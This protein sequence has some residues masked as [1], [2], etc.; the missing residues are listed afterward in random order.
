[1]CVPVR[2]GATCEPTSELVACSSMPGVTS[3]CAVRCVS[4]SECESAEACID[5]RCIGNASRPDPMDGGVRDSSTPDISPPDAGPVECVPHEWSCDPSGLE[6]RYCN[7]S[8][9]GFVREVD[10]GGRVCVDGLCE[11]RRNV[12][13][14]CGVLRNGVRAEFDRGPC[15]GSPEANEFGIEYLGRT[16]TIWV[17]R[18]D[19]LIVGADPWLPSSSPTIEV[20]RG[21]ELGGTAFCSVHRDPL[22]TETAEP[23]QSAHV[24]WLSER[25]ETL[26]VT[27]AGTR[28]HEILVRPAD[29]RPA[30][31][32]P[33]CSPGTATCSEDDP[34]VLSYCPADGQRLRT[35]RCRYLYDSYFFPGN[36]CVDG[37]CMVSRG[38]SCAD[39]VPLVRPADD[40]LNVDARFT[41][42][43]NDVDPGTSCLDVGMSGADRVFRLD[44]EAGERIRVEYAAG[45]SGGGH[46]EIWGAYLLQ[47]CESP[48]T[49]CVAG[50][51][52]YSE[53]PH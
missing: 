31:L 48:T 43:N 11:P 51:I 37:R 33:T 7:A 18:G 2:E 10:C 36:N 23:G 42:V 24:D 3:V 16:Y 53:V 25:R 13:F 8:G 50:D 30:A 28:A 52:G 9:D 20:T 1:M 27:F 26:R 38:D 5:G 45:I 22:I 39:A 17:D 44:L 15:P 46:S 32:P 19:T 21:C 29:P 49:S 34:E 41:G 14:L 6:A 40:E 35:H 4:G 12:H 47:D